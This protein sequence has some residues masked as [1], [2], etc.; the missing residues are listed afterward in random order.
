MRETK[1][2]CDHCGKV[3]D[4]MKDYTDGTLDIVVDCVKTDLCTDCFNQ[5]CNYIYNFCKVESGDEESE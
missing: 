1:I 2:Y 3:L 5:L 4:E